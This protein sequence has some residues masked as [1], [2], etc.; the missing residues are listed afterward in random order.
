ML[1]CCLQVCSSW[2]AHPVR[3][4]QKPVG[5]GVYPEVLALS[6]SPSHTGTECAALRLTVSESERFGH[7]KQH[8]EVP[9]AVLVAAG[10]P[11]R[12]HCLKKNRSIPYSH[13]ALRFG[14]LVEVH[15][16]FVLF[17]H[18]KW[19]YCSWFGR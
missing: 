11:P 13:S 2:A 15:I 14:L 3:V 5:R 17:T 8:P 16:P 7:N 9:R 12:L 18:R 19:S 10:S 1:E 6:C 4:N